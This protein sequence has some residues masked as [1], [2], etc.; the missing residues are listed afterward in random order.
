LW[1]LEKYEDAI[2]LFNKAIELDP[3]IRNG[4]R[5]DNCDKSGIIPRHKCS[6]CFD[7]D[8]CEECK[9]NG[10]HNIENHVLYKVY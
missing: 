9:N 6:I 8:L 1:Y 10:A 3:I 5:C 4:V 7:Y 2:E